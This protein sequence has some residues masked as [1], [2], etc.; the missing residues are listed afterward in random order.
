[1]NHSRHMFGFL[2][3]VVTFA[4][5]LVIMAGCG[6]K[7]AKNEALK[8]SIKRNAEDAYNNGNVDALDDHCVQD[9]IK[10]NPPGPDIVGLDA[11][12]EGII[13]TRLRL[14]D[15]RLTIGE[16]T[17]DG[18]FGSMQWVFQGTFSDKAPGTAAIAGKSLHETGC[19]FFRLESDKIAEEWMY[20]DD[21]GVQQQLGYK[22][23]PP[24]TKETYARVTVTQMKPEKLDDAVKI[25]QESVVAEAKKQKGYRGVI[26]LSDYKTGKGYSIAIWNSE[27]DAIANEQSGYYKGQ[28]DKF[29]D[30]MTAKPVREGYTV[31]VQE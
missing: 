24:L 8:A 14:P 12:K 29:K 21:R 5:L 1:M 28:V 26:L 25:Y 9:Y 27:E 13:N 6:Q 17:I 11:F 31:T 4:V 3:I 30:I 23:M 2:I 19:S 20:V 22:I 15:C 7:N 16:I 18:N 10:H